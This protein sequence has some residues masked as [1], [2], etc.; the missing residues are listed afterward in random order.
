[1]ASKITILS[2]DGKNSQTPLLESECAD[3]NNHLQSNIFH[4]QL[5]H[6]KWI[7][8][9]SKKNV[10]KVRGRYNEISEDS[11]EYKTIHKANQSQT[12]NQ[13]GCTLEECYQDKSNEEIVENGTGSNASHNL[14]SNPQRVFF[15]LG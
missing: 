15:A 8:S 2:D 7:I 4:P 6:E 12:F 5:N 13:N 3:R 1:M 9:S 14:L 10:S 11:N